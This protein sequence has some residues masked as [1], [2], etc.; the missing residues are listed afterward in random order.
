MAW[1]FLVSGVGAFYV[2]L[3]YPLWLW[4]KARAWSRPVRRGA[5]LPAVSVLIPV[6][7]GAA[8][9]RRKLESVLSLDY[10][11]ALL[12]VIVIS[13]GSDDGTD[14]IVRDFESRGV[15][16]VRTPPLGKAAALNAGFRHVRGEIVLLTDTRQIVRQD[17]LRRLVSCFADPQVGVVSGTLSIYAG[18]S[19]EEASTSLYRRYEN[20][21]R[22]NL[23][24]VDSLPGATGCLYAIRADLMVPIPDETLLDDVYVPMTAVLKGF[25]SVVA[26]DARAFDFP[27]DARSEFGR[28]VRTQAGIYQ[29]LRILPAVLGPGNRIWMQFWSLKVGRLMLPYLLLTAAISSWWLP[30]PWA[31]LAAGLEGAF[32]A[33]A[34]VGALFPG[35]LR[36][37][38]AAYTLISLLTAALVAV[39]VFFVPPARL[40]KASGIRPLPC[41]VIVE[42]DQE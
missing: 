40:W 16:L 4:L 14:A 41:S 1:V 27:T 36:L 20:W 29:L 26:E 2:L 34:V 12:H 38:S 17:S 8:F 6:R 9:I 19:V 10:P 21:I 28:K 7:N 3:G 15:E 33:G 42:R 35:R 30:W 39:S 23:S 31:A 5:E 37:A 25:R 24:Q 22:S 11:K 18:N 32:C 13:D